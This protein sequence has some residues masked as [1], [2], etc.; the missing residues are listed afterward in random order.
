MRCCPVVNILCLNERMSAKCIFLP[1]CP[2]TL[3]SQKVKAIHKLL[4]T[5]FNAFWQFL[6]P[7]GM[8]SKVRTEKEGASLYLILVLQSYSKLLNIYHWTKC[9]VTPAPSA[10]EIWEQQ[11]QTTRQQVQRKHHIKF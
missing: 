6:V 9:N 2:W 5:H 4:M 8:M 1:S 7:A 3:N 11:K 10:G